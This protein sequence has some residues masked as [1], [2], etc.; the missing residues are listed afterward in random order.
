LIDAE[1]LAVRRQGQAFWKRDTDSSSITKNYVEGFERR[2]IPQRSNVVNTH[3][4]SYPRATDPA[5]LARIY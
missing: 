2:P 1:F 3:E 5:T 4:A